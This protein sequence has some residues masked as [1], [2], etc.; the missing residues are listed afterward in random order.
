MPFTKQEI[1]ISSIFP[2]L[3]K[4]HQEKKNKHH[5]EAAANAFHM[6]P[7]KQNKPNK[8]HKQIEQWYFYAEMEPQN[9]SKATFSW[10]TQ[11]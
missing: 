9:S 1:Q 8:L 11:N 5:N 6:W 7:G 10:T 2:C 3:V 4:T